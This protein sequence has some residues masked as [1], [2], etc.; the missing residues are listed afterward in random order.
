M[1]YV[2]QVS[3]HDVDFTPQFNVEVHSSKFLQ[4]VLYSV[5]S[6]PF[7]LLN[8]WGKGYLLPSM[9]TIKELHEEHNIP[10]TVWPAHAYGKACSPCCLA[11]T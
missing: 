9:K 4:K 1:D 5:D 7:K 11:L 3:I 2:A 10:E 6:L 8:P